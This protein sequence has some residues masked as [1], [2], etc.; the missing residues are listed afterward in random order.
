[1]KLRM[2][3]PE[4]TRN[5]I[6][7]PSVKSATTGYTAG[8]APVAHFGLGNRTAVDVVV[9]TPSGRVLTHS[10]TADQHLRLPDG[11]R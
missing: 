8:V 10:A 9:T 11:C 1:M 3:V 2:L 7:N 6:K 4:A 5:Y